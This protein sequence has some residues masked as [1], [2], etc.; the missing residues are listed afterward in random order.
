[1]IWT[2]APPHAGWDFQ[3]FSRS[4]SWSLLL[5]R[6]LLISPRQLPS[7]SKLPFSS[8]RRLSRLLCNGTNS[9]GENEKIEMIGDSGKAVMKAAREYA[10]LPGRFRSCPDAWAER[11]L[12][13]FG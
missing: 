10:R 1:M 3:P 7:F 5:K 4:P 6:T 12:Y 8:P 9:G 11:F 13:S 2:G